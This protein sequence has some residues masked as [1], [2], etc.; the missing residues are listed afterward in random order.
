MYHIRPNCFN[1]YNDFYNLTQYMLRFASRFGILI[2]SG[3]LM[4]I[5]ESNDPYKYAVTTS[6]NYIDRRFCTASDISECYSTHYRIVSFVEINVRS[7]CKTLCHKP[8]FISHHFVV[9]VPFTDE[10]P[11]VS[12]KEDT[13]GF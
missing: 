4:Y 9:F 6:I 8:C 11:F 5:L 13:R 1:P 10:N 7:L 2:P 12:H 3:T